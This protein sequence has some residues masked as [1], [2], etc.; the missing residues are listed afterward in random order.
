MN[1][2]ISPSFPM[3]FVILHEGES[4]KVRSLFHIFVVGTGEKLFREI[5]NKERMGMNMADEG[6]SMELAISPATISLERIGWIKQCSPTIII[7]RVG[8]IVV[9]WVTLAAWKNILYP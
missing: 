5:A 6:I 7:G 9:R 2:L 4:L 1:Q 8:P 3:A